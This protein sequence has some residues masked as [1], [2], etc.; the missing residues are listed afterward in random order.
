MANPARDRYDPC[1]DPSRCIG[2]GLCPDIAPEVFRIPHPKGCAVAYDPDGWKPD[3]ADRIERAAA[4]CP[5]RAIV[6]DP[7]DGPIPSDAS[8]DGL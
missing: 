5:V 1:V 3:D 6:L 4:N 7:D 2:C 8:R